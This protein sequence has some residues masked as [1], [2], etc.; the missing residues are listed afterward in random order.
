MKLKEE[1]IYY[2][3]VQKKVV[4]KTRELDVQYL[5]SDKNFRFYKVLPDGKEHLG[6]EIVIDS[7][8]DQLIYSKSVKN[9]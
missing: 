7:C 9:P 5:G 3:S 8:L 4:R 6:G 2:S 1:Q